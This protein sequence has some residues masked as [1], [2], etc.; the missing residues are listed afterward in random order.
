M[1]RNIFWSPIIGRNMLD[2][3]KGENNQKDPLKGK[4]NKIFMQYLLLLIY[5]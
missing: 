4:N 3:L 1:G 5:N 2:P